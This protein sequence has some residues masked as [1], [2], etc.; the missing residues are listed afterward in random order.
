MNEY[1]AIAG[2]ARSHDDNGNL[3]VDRE[4]VMSFDYKNRLVAVTDAATGN[5][6]AEYRYY[7]DNRRAEKRVFSETAPGVLQEATAFFW[8]GWRCCEEQDVG[9]GQTEV[10]YVWSPVYVDELVQFERTAAHELGAGRFWVHQD[11]RADVVA[12]TDAA[13]SVVERRFYDDFGRLLDAQKEPTTESVTGLEYG[14]QGRRLDAETGLVYFRNRY[15]DPGT[16]RFLQRDPVWDASN[17][18]GWYTFVGNG[19]WDGLDPT[20]KLSHYSKIIVESLLDAIRALERQYEILPD[21]RPQGIQAVFE[22]CERSIQLRRTLTSLRTSLS[23]ILARSFVFTTVPAT[24]TIDM[25]PRLVA[26]LAVHQMLANPALSDHLDNTVGESTVTGAPENWIEYL[27]ESTVPVF[28]KTTGWVSWGLSHQGKTEWSGVIQ[29]DYYP[30]YDK[31]IVFPGEQ[32]NYDFVG[33]DEGD[34]KF[35]AQKLIHE[36]GGHFIIADLLGARFSSQYDPGSSS[37]GHDEGSQIET[38]IDWQLTPP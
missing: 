18:G 35:A 38:L 6:V 12:V 17:V 4:R 19:P 2:V 31:C 22:L 11:A 24:G 20:G 26:E 28:I 9:T 3:L 21:V 7:A 8:D 23:K 34:Y 10:S 30:E 14:F 36:F 32:Y 5:P 16:G 27:T 1:T 29:W 15:Y 25:N 37:G 13:G 33:F